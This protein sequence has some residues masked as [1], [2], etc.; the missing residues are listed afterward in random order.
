[1]T[2]HTRDGFWL[3]WLRFGL[4]RISNAGAWRFYCVLREAYRQR[5]DLAGGE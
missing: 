1:M 3:A 2:R 4:R 5:P